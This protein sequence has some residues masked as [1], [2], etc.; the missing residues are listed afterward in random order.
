VKTLGGI[1]GQK[2]GREVFFPVRGFSSQMENSGRVVMVAIA[3]KTLHR[4][5]SMDGNYRDN[6]IHDRSLDCRDKR[7]PVR[8]PRSTTPLPFICAD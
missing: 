5:L 2:K 7:Q 1:D 6:I 4:C 8:P 3:P